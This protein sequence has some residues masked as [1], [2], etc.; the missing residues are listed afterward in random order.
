MQNESRLDWIDSIRGLAALLVVVF[1]FWE[2]ARDLNPQLTKAGLYP[3][4]DWL[5]YNMFN[6]GKVG[7]VMFFAVSGF[8]IPFSLLK[9]SDHN[10]YRFM[11]S[12]FFRLY[13]I[14]WLSIIL[15][16]VV[17]GIRPKTWEFIAN[18]TMLQKFVGINDLL[19][20]YWTLQIELIF[21]GI[22]IVLFLFKWL[23]RDNVLYGFMYGFLGFAFVLAVIRFITDIKLPVALP[24]SLAVMFFGML[25]RKYILQESGIKKKHIMR[26]L[27]IYMLS[28]VPISL[29]AYNRNYGFDEVWY[30]YVATYVSALCLFTGLTSIWKIRNRTAVFLGKISYSVYLLHAI[31]LYLFERMVKIGR[32]ESL[33]MFGVSIVSMLAVIVI[34]TCTYYVIEKPMMRL[35]KKIA[36]SL[37]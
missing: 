10:V 31:G 20:V 14:Y 12:R 28:M 11:I 3:M 29:L 24:L 1:H 22:C 5:I 27:L 16:V 2:V 7:V 23:D 9:Y 35:G 26:S 25:W 33:G 6:I 21:Y 18:M 13:P 4:I 32:G 15:A 19:G 34:S 17:L 37:K 36:A 8:V 30:K